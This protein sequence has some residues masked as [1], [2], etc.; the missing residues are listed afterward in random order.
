MGVN[1]QIWAKVSVVDEILVECL[2]VLWLYRD[3]AVDLKTVFL[4]PAWL[5]R[6]AV[7]PII[8]FAQHDG[9]PLVV[10]VLALNPLRGPARRPRLG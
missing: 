10:G 2:I 7:L 3:L 4:S 5:I 6:I 8:D 9:I 1:F